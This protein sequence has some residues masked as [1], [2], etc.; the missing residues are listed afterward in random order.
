[1]MPKLTITLWQAVNRPVYGLFV[2]VFLLCLL[3]QWLDDAQALR[4]SRELVQQGNVWLLITGHLLHLNWAHFWMN[5]AGLLL[6]AVFFGAYFSLHA[7]LGLMLFCMLFCSMAL[8][9]LNPEL[10]L[11]VGMSGVLHGLLVAG[12]L[13]EYR[14]YP[15]SG[16][17]LMLLIVLKLGWEQLAGALPGSAAMAG[18]HVVVDVHLYGAIAGLMFSLL[19][20][21][22]HVHDRHQDGEYDQ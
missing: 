8:Y 21:L 15:K 18:G 19:H 22:I 11:Y 17:I 9:L 12:V 7:W 3:L 1:M 16:M 6:G 20:Q 13:E 4:Y 2:L 5:M 10:Q 14:R